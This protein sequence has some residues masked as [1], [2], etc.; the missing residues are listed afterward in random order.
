M[1]RPENL[2]DSGIG[3]NLHTDSI[4]NGIHENLHN[5]KVSKNVPLFWSHFTA[6]FYVRK[7]HPFLKIVRLLLIFRKLIS[8]PGLLFGSEE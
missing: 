6:I 3:D 1:Q 4:E 8:D 2:T 5:V 7:G